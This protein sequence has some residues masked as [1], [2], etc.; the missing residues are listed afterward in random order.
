MDVAKYSE[1]T[2]KT[3]SDAEQALVTAQI[4]R[5]RVMLETMLGYPLCVDDASENFYN[6]LG[7][8]PLECSCLS[9]DTETLL[10]PDDV[11]GSYRLFRYNHL[12]KFLFVDPF[13]AV[14]KV[15]LVRVQLGDL[16]DNT[17]VTIKTFDNDDMRA[18]VGRGGWG[19]YIQP[20]N[21]CM[22]LCECRDCVQLAVDADWLFEGCIPQDLLYVWADMVTYYA[23]C[24]ADIKSESILTHSY[25]KFDRIAPETLAQ[26]MAI[27]K[28]YA[29]PGGTAGVMPV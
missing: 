17:G 23:D 7:K 25:T 14:Y 12:D 13:V 8:S 16:F 26:N 10:D 4:A 15:K 11:E 6:E 18:Q 5:T 1:L 21:D 9:V 27:I 3:L 29:G 22:C 19:K 24:K 20:C 2:G 28:R